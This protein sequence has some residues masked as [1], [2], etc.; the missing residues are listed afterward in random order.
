MTDGAVMGG[1]KASVP[2]CKSVIDARHTY[3]YGQR[4]TDHESGDAVARVSQFV[5]GFIE[6][7]DW[8]S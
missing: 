7:T 6:R 8:E 5:L 3:S 2:T 1:A 4:F